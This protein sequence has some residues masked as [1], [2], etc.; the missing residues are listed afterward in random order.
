MGIQHRWIWTAIKGD[1]CRPNEQYLLRLPVWKKM[2]LPIRSP[3][4]HSPHSA[5]RQPSA[6]KEATGPQTGQRSLTCSKQTETRPQGEED[7]THGMR[8]SR[9]RPSS[10]SARSKEAS[11]CGGE[12]K[13]RKPQP[14]PANHSNSIFPY[15]FHQRPH[16]QTQRSRA[17]IGR[18]E[19]A[20]VRPHTQD[21][22]AT[23]EDAAV[24]TGRDKHAEAPSGTASRKG[25]R[26]HHHRCPTVGATAER[27]QPHP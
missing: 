12:K 9:T 25:G 3:N 4:Q 5:A 7:G 23:E 20:S 18:K 21:P 17:M 10:P 13:M 14:P 19:R 2:A 15:S 6:P 27:H 22:K 26:K 24:P 8:T 16:Q 1:F 11:C